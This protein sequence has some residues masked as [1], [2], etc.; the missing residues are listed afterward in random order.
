MSRMNCRD[1]SARS[2][3]GGAVLLALG[4]FSLTA[5]QGSISKKPPIHLV[6]NMD[7]QH[8]YDPQEP[9]DFFEDGRGMRSP[10][11]GTVALGSLHADSHLDHGKLADGSWADA[12]PA[13]MDLDA[14]LLARGKERYNIYCTPCHDQAGTGKGTVVARGFLAPPSFHDERLR[15]LTL[16]ELYDIVNNGVRNMPGYG[17]QVPVD[18]RWAIAAWVRTLQVAKDREAGDVPASV[19]T[20]QGW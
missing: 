10:V 13:G 11:E 14:A 1:R 20:E 16:G 2:G 4:V 5:C 19:R 6:Q 17:K 8:R 7:Q 9:N 12:F 18:D 15:A 3:L